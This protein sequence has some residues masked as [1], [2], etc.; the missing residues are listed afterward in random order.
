[1]RITQYSFRS[2]GGVGG[3]TSLC[4]CYF[5]DYL[6]GLRINIHKS[7]LIGVGMV[8]EELQS[9]VSSLCC[10]VGS[11]TMRYLGLQLGGKHRDIQSWNRL[12]DLV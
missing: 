5:L 7:S 8:I 12:L 2:Y 1:M 10:Q 3:K 11:L 9:I 6:Y 4:S